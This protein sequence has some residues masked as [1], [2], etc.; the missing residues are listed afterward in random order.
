MSGLEEVGIPGSDYLR[1]ALTNCTDPI[2]AI[3]EFQEQNGILLPSLKPA[4]PF[5]DLHGVMRLEFHQSVVEELQERLLKRV[6]ELSSGEDKG[7]NKQLNELL[8]K[9]FPLI[10]VKSL[11]P[12]V[13]CVMKHLPKIKDSYLAQI[14]EDRELYED[15][16]V[17]VK[18]QIWQDDQALFGDEVS[19]LLTQYIEEKQNTLFD[20]RNSALTFFT[21]STK[22]RRQNPVVQKLVTMVGKNIKLY[23]MVL[24]FLRTLF[25]R[26]RNVHYCTLRAEILMALH[27]LEIHEICSVDPCHKFTWCLDACIRERFVD[28]K[29]ARELQ[30]FLDGI[31]RGQEQVLGD[32]SMILCDPFATNTVSLSILK[33][34]ISASNTESLPR[35]NEDILLLLRMLVL[36]IGSW[37]MIDSQVFKEPKLDV[38]IVTRFLPGIVSMLVDDNIRSICAKIP[39]EKLEE[40]RNPPEQYIRFIR[41]SEVASIIALHHALHAMKQKD[42]VTLMR[43]LPELSSCEN[44]RAYDDTMMHS[45]VSYLILM[46]EEFSQE[47]FCMAVFDELMLPS[48]SKESALRHTLRLVWYVHHR[49][50]PHR[51]EALMTAMKPSTEHSEAVHTTFQLLSDKINTYQPSPAPL[52]EH[53][54]SPLMSVPAPTPMQ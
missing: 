30:G 22:V 14:K 42:K 38:N 23:D 11:R 6:A 54:N 41:N 10:K 27:E 9:S 28:A 50:P 31:R 47:D 25:L 32:L 52:E 7:K 40:T 12:I 3:E 15:A 36:G 49:L 16:S 26:T 24:Q 4:L 43:V 53:I 29:R 17:E 5:L 37:E 46:A 39:D 1:E 45:L 48:I 44:E 2:A 35:N 13:M 21:A 18:R 20:H 19:P 51:L 34:L 8:E 33:H